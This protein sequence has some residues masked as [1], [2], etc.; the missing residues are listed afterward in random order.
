MTSQQL[1]QVVDERIIRKE[2]RSDI[3]TRGQARAL[4]HAA[5]VR[6]QRL[7]QPVPLNQTVFVSCDNQQGLGLIEVRQQHWLAEALDI[8]GRDHRGW[9]TQRDLEGFHRGGGQRVTACEPQT[10]DHAPALVQ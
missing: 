3:A 10:D 9:P 4:N 6:N 8:A 7:G 1:S 2:G 5:V